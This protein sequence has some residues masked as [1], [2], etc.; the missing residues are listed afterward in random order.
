MT[1]LRSSGRLVAAAVGLALAWPSGAQA[2]TKLR[3][4][5]VTEYR[6]RHEVTLDVGKLV[7]AGAVQPA[8]AVSIGEPKPRCWRLRT[9]KGPQGSRWYRSLLT[10]TPDAPDLTLDAKLEGVYDI[11]AQVRAVHAGGARDM[12][13]EP[14][15]S[16]PMAFELAL[17]DGSRRERVQAKGFPTH[18]YD[19]EVLACHRWPLTGRKLVLRGIGLPVYLYGLRFVPA[20]TRRDRLEAYC[21]LGGKGKKF[22]RW[23]AT[24]HVTIVKEPGKHFAFPGAALLKNGDLAV[25]YR[26]GTKHGWEAS[27]RV[28]LSRSTDGGRTWLPRVPII[29]RPGEDR[30]PGI[31]QMSDGTVIATSNG[32]MAVSTDVGRT[33]GKPMPTPVSSPMGAVEDEDGHIVYGGQET[34]QDA[35]TR[36]GGR[37]AR[38]FACAAYRSGDK[39]RSWEKLGVA[40]YALHMPSP[41]GE[42]RDFLWHREPFLCVV[43][44]RLYIMC[45]CNSLRGDGFLRIIRSTDRGRTWGP[46]IKTPVWGKPAHLLHLRDGRLLMTYGYRRPPWGVRACLSNDYGKTWDIDNEIIIRMDGG[47]GPGAKYTRITGPGDLGYPVSVQLADGRIFTAYYFNTGGSGC[48]VAGTFWELPE[49]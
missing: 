36:I 12:G 18:H 47:A 37:H 38:L 1:R 16:R 9:P 24:D 7:A 30:G 44:G 35:F 11:Y 29:D 15:D 33:W 4:V 10:A 2:G 14:A 13:L 46:P 28:C 31:F 41:P 40:T 45:V 23:L 17:D 32:C 49:K 22:T 8:S 48:F 20:V 19:T 5:Q 6:L 3:K 43:P 27:G 25:V 39:G 42:P 21:E 26:E 34:V